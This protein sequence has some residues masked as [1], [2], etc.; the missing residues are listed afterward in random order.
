MEK[1]IF[2][3]AEQIVR[4]NQMAY[5]AYLPMIEDVCSRKVSEDEL[6]HLLDDLLGFACDEKVL[7]LYKKVCRR[8]LYTCSAQRTKAIE[9]G[10]LFSY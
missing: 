5:E 1:Q 9:S 8:Y 2:R 4:L 3:F 10:N 7:G 6:S